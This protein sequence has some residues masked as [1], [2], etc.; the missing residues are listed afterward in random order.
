MGGTLPGWGGGKDGLIVSLKIKERSTFEQK[1][2]LGIGY[3]DSMGTHLLYARPMMR[4][5]PGLRV[6][7]A[8]QSM[9]LLD[10]NSN[11]S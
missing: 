10:G 4:S 5:R 11:Y 3:K 8:G 6:S 1:G 9:E 2:E 7:L